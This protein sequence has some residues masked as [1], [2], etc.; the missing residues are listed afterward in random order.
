MK[1]LLILL[2]LVALFSC[3]TSSPEDI[4]E[5]E[6]WDIYDTMKEAFLVGDLDGIMQFYHTDFQHENDDYDRELIVWELR[7]I[8]HETIDFS[9]LEF[10][11]Y[12]NF[13]EVSFM[14][15]LDDEIF[16][17]PETFGDISFF[18][19]TLQDEWKICGN[20]FQD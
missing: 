3:E 1:Y 2:L 17:E 5:M 19:L 20:N 4:I 10:V 14:L 11:I 6:I 18:Y 8:N 15:K 7:M 16:T 12:D 9:E 13:V